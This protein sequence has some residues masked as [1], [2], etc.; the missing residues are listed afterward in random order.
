MTVTTS[1]CK[2]M[3]PTSLEV[4]MSWIRM[5]VSQLPMSRPCPLPCHAK[6]RRS[7]HVFVGSVKHYK[8]DQNGDCNT[9]RT[10][11]HHRAA[12]E[13]NW[14]SMRNTCD[15]NTTTKNAIIRRTNTTKNTPRIIW[16]TCPL[17]KSHLFPVKDLDSSMLQMVVSMRQLPVWWQR[18]GKEVLSPRVKITWLSVSM[19]CLIF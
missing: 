4:T 15:L 13:P 6:R 2:I 19:T 5:R 11:Q 1:S 12:E 14:I 17:E 7:P 18:C 10:M 9:T 3:L 16:P 8:T